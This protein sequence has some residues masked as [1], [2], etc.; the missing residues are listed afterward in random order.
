MMLE[1]CLKKLNGATFS[2]SRAMVKL[3]ELQNSSSYNKPT[4]FISEKG[5]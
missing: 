1:I 2:T 3:V 4:R 5:M